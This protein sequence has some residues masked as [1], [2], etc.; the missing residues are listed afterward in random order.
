MSRQHH[1]RRRGFTLLELLVVVAIL[2]VLATMAIAMFQLQ[3]Q[4]AKR[5][6]AMTNL[7]A[8]SKLQRAYF[9]ENGSHPAAIPVPLG[10]PGQKQNW[11][12]AA[13]A[14]FSTLGFQTDGSVFYVYD[15]DSS[16]GGCACPSNGCFTA[17]AYGDSDRDGNIAVVAYF[18]AD[19]AGTVC[20]VQVFPAVGPPI[21][22]LDGF[23]ILEQP[24]DIFQYSGPVVDDY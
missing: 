15:V 12:A 14:A 17:S 7:E 5:S 6:E 20:P 9:G 2:G 8:I 16:S 23:P 18:H 21:D 22:P 11:D 4:R 10:P 3:Q 24:V 1:N 19:G 13:L